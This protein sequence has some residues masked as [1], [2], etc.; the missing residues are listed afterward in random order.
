MLFA[1]NS[2]NG[3]RGAGY[4]QS[5][6]VSLGCEGKFHSGAARSFVCSKSKNQLEAIFDFFRVN[7]LENDFPAI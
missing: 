5:G 3:K 2:F 7:L 4:S 1:Q 6:T